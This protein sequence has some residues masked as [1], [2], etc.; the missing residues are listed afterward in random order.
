MCSMQVGV[1]GYHGDGFTD[2]CAANTLA[3]AD[4]L[5]TVSYQWKADGAA[6]S[7]VGWVAVLLATQH[8]SSN[9]KRR[10]NAVFTIPLNFKEL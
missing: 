10:P 2:F 5:G 8:T 1:T 4:G 3:D 7:C 9:P 6:I